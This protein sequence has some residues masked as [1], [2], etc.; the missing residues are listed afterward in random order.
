MRQRASVARAGAGMPTIEKLTYQGALNAELFIE[1][2]KVGCECWCVGVPE[3]IRRRASSACGADD[4]FEGCTIDQSTRA[5]MSGD[6][7]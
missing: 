7:L 1:L 6:S 2:L 5:C 3:P 4:A